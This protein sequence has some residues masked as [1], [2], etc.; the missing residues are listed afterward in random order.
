MIIPTLQTADALA[1]STQARDKASAR[2]AEQELHFAGEPLEKNWAKVIAARAD[3]ELRERQF[4]VANDKHNAAVEG[5]IK[6][7]AYAIEGQRVADLQK[8]AEATAQNDLAARK[9]IATI[10]RCYSIDWKLLI[11]AQA[12]GGGSQSNFKYNLSAA[13]SEALASNGLTFGMLRI[14]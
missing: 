7:V 12:L 3:A 1:T 11:E 6:R 5:E 9:A 13:L 14:T 10:A 2:L 8:N 4:Q